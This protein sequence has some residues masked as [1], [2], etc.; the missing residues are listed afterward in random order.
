M[1]NKS[2]FLTVGIVLIFCIIVFLLFSFVIKGKTPMTANEFKTFMQE[3]G[4]TVSD[5]TSQYSK[6]DYV[7]QIYVA[8]ANNSSYQIE[9]YEIS[10][11][12]YARMFYNNNKTII[13]S[14]KGSISSHVNINMGNYSKYA[15]SS[16]NKYKVIARIDN[17]VIY[18]NVDSDNKDEVKELL[19]EIGY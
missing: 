16:D 15:L 17:T 7:K 12:K 2:L 9:F 13:E 19:K 6:Y 3:N 4:F 10:D 8:V 18:L 1:K 14:S 11:N 5:V